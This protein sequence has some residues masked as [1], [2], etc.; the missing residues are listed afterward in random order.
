MIDVAVRVYGPLN[1][2][3]APDRRQRSWCGT[4]AG[5]TT[6]KDFV[7]GLGVPHPE[8][9]L[10]VVNGV[11]VGFDYILRAH[12]RIAVYPRFTRIDIGSLTRVRPEP[13]EPVRFVA[14]VHL[15]KLARRLRL[16]GLDTAYRADADDVSLARAAA[17]E[18]RVLL[19]R[20][21]ALLMRRAIAHGYFVRSTNPHEQ[22]VEI[23]QRFA[24]CELHPFSRC[25]QCNG[26]LEEVPK[27]DVDAALLPLTRQHYDVFAR[28]PGCGRVYWQ[29]SHWERLRTALDAA[30][31]EAEGHRHRDA[32]RRDAPFTLQTGRRG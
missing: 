25:L 3:L 24:P 30:R 7:E 17:C 20:D 29:G 15:G 27:A 21:Q 9:D 32:Q 5:R 11:P 16:A 12:D 14:D 28:C 18:S 23:L 13:I 2:F 6:V 19:T 8:I 31:D 4:L 26:V 10:I 1:D 22:F